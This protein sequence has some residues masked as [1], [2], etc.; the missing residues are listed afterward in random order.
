MEP[1]LYVDINQREYIPESI[2][3]DITA[4][5]INQLQYA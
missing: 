5:Y 4:E 1:S 2:K 3:H